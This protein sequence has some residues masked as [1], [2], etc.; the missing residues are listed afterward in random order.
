MKYLLITLA[1]VVLFALPQNA[2]A[3]HGHCGTGYTYRC[4]HS[5]CGCPIY[6]RRVIVRYDCYHR[7]VYRYVSVP[8]VHRCRSHYKHH[9]H[10]KKHHYSHHRPQYRHSS[11]TRITY[12]SPYGSIS[13]CR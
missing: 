13:Y 10:H 6:K 4:G 7:P 9:K 1:S 12:R 2:Q 11:H 8:V 3:A 5:A